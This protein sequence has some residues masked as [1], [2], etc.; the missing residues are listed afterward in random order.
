MSEIS[1]LFLAIL[2]NRVLGAKP[3]PC[4]RCWVSL[5]LQAGGDGRAVSR[6]RAVGR[7]VGVV[8]S[9]R[10][11][12]ARLKTLQVAEVRGPGILIGHR[13]GA[14]N[15]GRLGIKPIHLQRAGK[16]GIEAGDG[17]TAAQRGV[18]QSA[19]TGAGAARARAGA[20]GAGADRSA[21]AA[22][23]AAGRARDDAAVDAQRAAAGLVRG[24][25]RCR[26]CSGCSAG[27]RCRDCSPWPGPRRRSWTSMSFPSL[28]Q[29]LDPRRIAQIRRRHVLWP[30]R[31]DRIGKVRAG[32]GVV[33]PP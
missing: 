14:E 15:A 28:H 8:E 5:E 6:G 4:S 16:N 30:V 11:V 7:G 29:L 26:Q 2:I 20:A 3:K 1:R 27:S 23:A 32:L 25:C 9:H 22:G 17:G 33:S 13:D 18:N 19:G 31:R 24:E 21:E 12:G 10:E